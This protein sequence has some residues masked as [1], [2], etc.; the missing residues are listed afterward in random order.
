M[1]STATEHAKTLEQLRFWLSQGMTIKATDPKN[2]RL[3]TTISGLT[4]SK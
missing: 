4:V 3:G 1:N 2:F